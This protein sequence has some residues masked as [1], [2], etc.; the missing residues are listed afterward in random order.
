M[1]NMLGSKR[2]KKW[3]NSLNRGI[4]WQGWCHPD[5]KTLRKKMKSYEDLP[6]GSA[7]KRIGGW[8]EWC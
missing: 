4:Y 7:Y 6:D 8:F 5:S 1:R 3:R 2:T